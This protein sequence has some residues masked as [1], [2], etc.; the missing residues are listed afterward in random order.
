MPINDMAVKITLTSTQG[1][2]FLDS[3]AVEY[4]IPDYCGPRVIAFNPS[5]PTFLSMDAAL[6]VLT[7]TNNLVPDVGVYNV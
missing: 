2:N 5:M 6:T 7:L 3:K 1:I 4:V